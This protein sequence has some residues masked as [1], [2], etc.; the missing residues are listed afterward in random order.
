MSE[1]NC[2]GCA[3]RDA[4]VEAP[5]KRVDELQRQVEDLQARLGAGRTTRRRVRRGRR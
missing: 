4:L 1:A 5:P 2:P 3:Q